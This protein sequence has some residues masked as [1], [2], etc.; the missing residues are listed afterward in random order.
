MFA[1]FIILRSMLWVSLNTS[2]LPGMGQWRFTRMVM[3]L[4]LCPREKYDTLK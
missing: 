1:R 2:R 4:E 3:D